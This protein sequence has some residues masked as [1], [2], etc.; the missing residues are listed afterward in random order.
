MTFNNFAPTLCTGLR[1]RLLCLLLRTGN[2]FLIYVWLPLGVQYVTEE[3]DRSLSRFIT[4]LFARRLRFDFLPIHVKYIVGSST[5]KVSFWGAS[6]FPNQAI[7]PCSILI[8]LDAP[9][10]RTTWQ[11]SGNLQ[12]KEFSF[13]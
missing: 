8:F 11:V 10:R 2:T 4:G 6:V 7:P 3:L 12:T 5:R 1:D 9:T 13:P